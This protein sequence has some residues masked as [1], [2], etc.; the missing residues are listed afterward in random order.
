VN[1]LAAGQDGVAGVFAD[2]TLA[3]EQRFALAGDP[4]LLPRAFRRWR[5]RRR[6]WGAG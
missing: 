2:R 6:R 5:A 3:M 4:V 1:I